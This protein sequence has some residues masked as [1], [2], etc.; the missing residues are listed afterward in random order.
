MQH[1]SPSLVKS[2]TQQGP[3]KSNLFIDKVHDTFISKL[4]GAFLEMFGIAITN[5]RIE[6]FRVVNQELANNMSQQAFLTAQVQNQ[7]ANLTGQTEIA[8]TQQRRDAE[9]SRYE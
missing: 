5:I 4:R 8:C 1:D 7:L 9:V 2:D 6:S 3:A